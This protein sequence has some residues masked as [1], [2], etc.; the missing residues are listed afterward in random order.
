MKKSTR[1]LLIGGI[2]GAATL[3]AELMEQKNKSIDELIEMNNQKVDIIRDLKEM[4][5]LSE[6]AIEQ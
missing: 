6:D 4:L 1:I 2:V 3:V 5:A